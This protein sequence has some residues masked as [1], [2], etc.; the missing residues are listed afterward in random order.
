MAIEIA[1]IVLLKSCTCI[2]TLWPNNGRAY[3]MNKR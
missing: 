3:K 1:V 2:D